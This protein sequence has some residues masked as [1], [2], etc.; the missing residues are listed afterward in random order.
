[1]SNEK[2]P[3]CLGYIGDYSTQLCGDYH[4]HY[5]DPYLTTS[6]M[7]SMRVLRGSNESLTSKPEL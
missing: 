7:E 2:N 4:D 3:G 5:N 1:M 6:M